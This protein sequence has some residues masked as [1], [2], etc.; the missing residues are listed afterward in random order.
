MNWS[1]TI[2]RVK[3]QTDRAIMTTM[4][5]EWKETV[6]R[7]DIWIPKSAVVGLGT[8]CPHVASWFAMRKLNEVMASINQPPTTARAVY[9]A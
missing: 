4:V 5:V 8:N 7:R 9:L 3:R 1:T 6:T 2:R